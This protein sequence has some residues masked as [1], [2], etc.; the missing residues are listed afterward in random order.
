MLA[1]TAGE[2]SPW[3][4]VWS[5]LHCKS[6]NGREQM[7]LETIYGSYT[8]SGGDINE[9]ELCN[10]WIAC[11]CYDN[12]AVCLNADIHICL[13]LVGLEGVIAIILLLDDQPT[14]SS[15]SF[16]SSRRNNT[17][18][19][20]YT[21]QQDVKYSYR[22]HLLVFDSQEHATK[23]HVLQDVNWSCI[24]FSSERELR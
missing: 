9:C 3:D 1:R 7:S 2:A 17:K 22:N 13:V 10:C 21:F 4:V 19:N 24:P 16:L 20:R 8:L 14:K 11:R 18:S 5:R 6:W 15:A 23:L 12:L